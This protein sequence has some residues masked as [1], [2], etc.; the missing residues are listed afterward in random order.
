MMLPR[1]I[2]WIAGGVAA[3]VVAGIAAGPVL[4][5]VEQPDYKVEKQD[6]SIEIRSYGPMIAAEAQVQGERKSAINEGFRLIAG[7]IF[8]KNEPQAKIEMT[9]PVEQQKSQKIAMTSPVTQQGQENSWTVRFIMPKSWTM[10]TLPA[11]S[12]PRV[13]LEPL[14]ARRFLVVTFSGLARDEAIE[15]RTAELRQYAAS[16]K[17]ATVGEPLL[18]FYNPPW[19]LPMLRRNEIMLEL[20]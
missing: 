11:P 12:D 14:P 13:K 4:S 7:Y 10:Q 20:A 2:F 6:G 16:N 19:T 9:T 5:R 8:G 1:A 17:L 15:S 3:A 18:A